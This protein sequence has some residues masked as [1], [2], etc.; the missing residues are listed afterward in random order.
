M[1]ADL[2]SRVQGQ[3][4]RLILAMMADRYGQMS[5]TATSTQMT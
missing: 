3:G 1:V 2:S 4:D 5:I